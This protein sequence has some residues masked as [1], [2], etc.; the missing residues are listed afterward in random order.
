MSVYFLT[1]ATLLN[2]EANSEIFKRESKSLKIPREI[3]H[4]IIL[5]D[6]QKN[7]ICIEMLIAQ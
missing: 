1:N 6:E 4:F 5:I 3:K 7:T 2:N